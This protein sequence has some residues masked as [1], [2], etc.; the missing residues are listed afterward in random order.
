MVISAKKFSKDLRR[1]I[2]HRLWGT[3]EDFYRTPH[4]VERLEWLKENAEK[5]ILELGCSTGYVSQYVGV[6]TGVDLD[7][8]RL[9]KGRIF[10][11]GTRFLD[12]DARDLRFPNDSFD[13]VIVSEILEHMPK[14]AS[15]EVV[16][17]AVRVGRKILITIPKQER[18]LKNP[19]HVWIP[20]QKEEFEELL[21]GF[22]HDITESK[23]GVYFFATM[24]AN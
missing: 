24:N 9:W 2:H 11:R 12:M 1:K 7:S 19:E 21:H 10:R 14:L 22:D 17:E 18:F 16:E 4:Q 3:N 6:H 8:R 23:S 15:R 5:K 13:T 20:L